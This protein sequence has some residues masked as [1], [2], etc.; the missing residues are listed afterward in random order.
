[1]KERIWKAIAANLVKKPSGVLHMVL[2]LL[3]ARLVFPEVGKPIDPHN[4]VRAI[5]IRGTVVMQNAYGT[6]DWAMTGD[7]FINDANSKVC[8]REEEVTAILVI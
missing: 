6:M 5:V 7:T 8:G 4:P 2:R 1:M 3:G